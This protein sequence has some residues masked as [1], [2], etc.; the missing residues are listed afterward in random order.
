[1][2]SNKGFSLVELIVVIAIMAIIAGVAIPVFTTYIDKSNKAADEQLFADIEDALIYALV[3]D[4]S[5]TGF[6]AV[7]G[8]DGLVA[9]AESAVYKVLAEA[10]LHE[11]G[12]K[13]NGWNSS[14]ISQAVAEAVANSNFYVDANGEINLEKVDDLLDHVQD[15]SNAYSDL[16]SD[17]E[18]NGDKVIFDVADKLAALDTEALIGAWSEERF[19]PDQFGGK[20]ILERYSDFGVDDMV[21]NLALFYANAKAMVDYMNNFAATTNDAEFAASASAFSDYFDQFN[22]RV[23]SASGAL[24]VASLLDEV[25]L[26]MLGLAAPQMPNP[27]AAYEGTLFGRTLDAYFDSDARKGDAR[28]FI[29]TLDIA[30][31]YADEFKDEIGSGNLFKSDKVSQY[32]KDQLNAANTLKTLT[33]VTGAEG[34]VVVVVTKNADGTF[35][36]VQYK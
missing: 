2:K 21:T 8:A 18:A 34:T 12:L 7:I 24:A 28:A 16:V 23:G 6:A 35:S 26:N 9:D 4:E 15:L 30:T 14:S 19:L 5:A 11:T 20:S 22:E 3:A 32:V 27:S 1:M 33:G 17:P 31:D 13:Y 25:L 36:K 10:K 29:A